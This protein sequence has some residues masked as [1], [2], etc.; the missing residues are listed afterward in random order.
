MAE[1]TKKSKSVVY[2]LNDLRK[3]FVDYAHET[4]LDPDGTHKT[5]SVFA[6]KG[7]LGTLEK[8]A[9]LC[10]GNDDVK[11]EW[12]DLFET[13]DSDGGET[14]KLRCKVDFT[15]A[16]LLRGLDF[17]FSKATSPKGA[18]GAL[19]Q[20]MYGETIKIFLLTG[21]R[22]I[23]YPKAEKI[24]ETLLYGLVHN[25][26]KSLKG[27]PYGEWMGF[28]ARN[29]PDFKYTRETVE[30]DIAQ[31]HNRWC[32]TDC[33]FAVGVFDILRKRTEGI[34]WLIQNKN[35]ELWKDSLV[36]LTEMCKTELLQV[37]DGVYVG[38]MLR[39][40]VETIYKTKS[41]ILKKANEG[42]LTL[43]VGRAGVG[44]AMPKD[45]LIPT[46]DG[47]KLLGDIKVGDFV[48]DRKGHPTKVL[49]VYD[50][51]VRRCFEL[52]FSDGRK[53]RCCDEHIWT[54][55]TSRKNMKNLTLRE[56]M[57]KGIRI[58]AK[59]GAR[60][61]MPI[62]GCVEFPEKGLP[63]HPYIL[64]VF[65]GDGCCTERYLTLSSNDLPVVEKVAKLLN[66]TAKKQS[67]NNYSWLF[68][69][70]GRN[71][72]TREVFGDIASWV[73]RGSNEKAIPI[74]YLHGSREQRIALLQ[75][76][77]DTDGSVSC[78]SNGRASFSTTS[79]ELYAGVSY[80]LRSLGL[81]TS[82][83]SKPVCRGRVKQD[84]TC[85]T[86][87]VVST[88][89]KPDQFDVCFSL[90]RQIEKLKSVFGTWKRPSKCTERVALTDVREIEPCEQVCILVDN[91]EHLFLANDFLVTHNTESA[92]RRVK[93]V[94]KEGERW[95]FVALSN[96][97]CA[98]G[99]TRAQ[100]K[101]HMSISPSSIERCRVC[102]TNPNVIEDEFSQWGQKELGLFLELLENSNEMIIMGDDRQIPSFLGRGCLLHDVSELLEKECP[103]AVVKLKEVKRAD[104]P[105]LIRSVLA[106]SETADINSL[107]QWFCDGNPEDVTRDW[108]RHLP[109]NGIIISG[110]NANVDMLNWRMFAYWLRKFLADDDDVLDDHEKQVL[111]D[112]IKVIKNNGDDDEEGEKSMDFHDV[113]HQGLATPQV[114]DA[115]RCVLS[116]YEDT[117][118]VIMTKAEDLCTSDDINKPKRHCVFCYGHET[119]EKN[120]N[121]KRFLMSERAEIVNVMDDG[122]LMKCSR[123]GELLLP[124]DK[125][126]F[127]VAPGFAITVNKAQGL[128]WDDVLIYTPHIAKFN[129]NLVSANAFYVAASRARSNLKIIPS[130]HA[131]DSIRPFESFTNAFDITLCNA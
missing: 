118:P 35:P 122:Y 16:T 20:E 19:V 49:E 55:Y 45:T 34:I 103:R 47:E 92:V 39:A 72:T 37:R 33:E 131:W 29:Y 22:K 82:T 130:N 10:F 109:K 6:L 123:G 66:A 38:S 90:P 48:F 7:Y 94:S 79:S 30:K 85:S 14:K 63:V 77:F 108:G 67:G 106:F 21:E 42:H 4:G 125:A 78:K 88:Y 107:S 65:L 104:S 15:V 8:D 61:R 31:C 112:A 70:G 116:H 98:M 91:P 62:N 93:D 71:I 124:F 41:L 9:K 18:T 52:T 120:M 111:R 64:G 12:A 1:K 95:T 11:G 105:E 75:G 28:I 87:Y 68:M 127:S 50:R 40:D 5:F 53:T 81:P 101:C 13:K 73:M 121:Y 17:G 115:L 129:Y 113:R 59:S 126:G 57:E 74:D 97:V 110:A 2:Y 60:F 69:K 117:L 84:G 86:D 24:A 114:V 83:S 76:L 96:S 100:K 26:N 3:G 43:Y 102:R 51:G 119:E 128:E 89:L 54:C 44:K 80:L 36:K 23:F 58:S 25:H 99:A 27:V 32:V 46:P 56:M